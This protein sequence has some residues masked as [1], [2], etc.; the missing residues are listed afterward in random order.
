MSEEITYYEEELRDLVAEL[1]A[2]L[3]GLKKL[4][5]AGKAERLA[6]LAS[7]H[8]RVKQVLHSY[9]VEMRDLPRE[10]VTE[11]DVRSREFHEKLQ[12]LGAGLAASRE[13][14]ERSEL[15]VLTVDEMTTEEVLQEADETQDKSLSAL[16]RMQK[17]IAASKEVGTEAAARLQAQTDQLKNVDTDIMKVK[18]NLARADVLVRAFV[19]KMATDKIIMGFMCLI[20]IGVVV[21]IVY[22]VVDPKG[23]DDSGLSVPDAIVPSTT[24]RRLGALDAFH[25]LLARR[26]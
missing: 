14:A 23:A 1:E 21:I 6:E 18:S 19:R 13:D 17:D 8:L 3:K 9:K 7:R 12:I 5:N 26:R 16:Q 4:G 20:F 25:A 15:G 10:D 2:G 24:T 11:F 22:K